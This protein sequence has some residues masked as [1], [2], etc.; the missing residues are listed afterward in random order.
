MIHWDHMKG[1]FTIR[2]KIKIKPVLKESKMN[3]IISININDDEII[4]MCRERIR[5]LTK[6]A[7]SEYV[8]WDSKELKKRTCMSW[9]TIQSTF[10][11]D[12][13]FIKRKIGGKWYFPVRETK[14]FLEKWLLEQE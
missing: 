1:S 3:N 5:E 8:F 4:K 7:D 13:R 9:N 2:H 10:F 11:Y 6:E 12:S 14:I